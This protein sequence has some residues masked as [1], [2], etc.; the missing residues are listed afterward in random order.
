MFDWYLP[1]LG[2][3]SLAVNPGNQTPYAITDDQLKKV[4]EFLTK[5]R[6]Q[7]GMFGSSN[8]PIAQA[9]LAGDIV[10][11]RRAISTST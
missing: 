3:A 5:L 9:M 8:Q 4:K 11:S 10:A 7:I 1:N 6:P 2:N